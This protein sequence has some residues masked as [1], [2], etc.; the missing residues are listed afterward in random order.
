MFA[1]TCLSF[2]TAH[3]E[4]GSV[5]LKVGANGTVSSMSTVQTKPWFKVNCRLN[6]HILGHS[7]PPMPFHMHC[8]TCS[9]LYCY[10]MYCTNVNKW[11][12]GLIYINIVSKSRHNEIE[13]IIMACSI[14]NVT[15][16]KILPSS[17][18][19]DRCLFLFFP[20]LGF[21]PAF[22]LFNPSGHWVWTNQDNGWRYVFMLFPPGYF[23]YILNIHAYK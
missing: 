2:K 18:E 3:L 16:P 15:I 8:S 20:F 14:L 12:S 10:C 21:V 1:L 22:F 6:N 17:R 4:N 19:Y 9:W 7:G 23:Q 13:P 11:V 5:F